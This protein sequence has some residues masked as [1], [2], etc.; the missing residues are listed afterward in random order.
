MYALCSYICAYS[1]PSGHQKRS[2]MAPVLS[3]AN[4][5]QGDGV[6]GD[7]SWHRSLWTQILSLEK[8]SILAD[9]SLYLFV[10]IQAFI[11]HD[12]MHLLQMLVKRQ[13]GPLLEVCLWKT[14]NYFMSNKYLIDIF[15]HLSLD[16]QKSVNCHIPVCFLWFCGLWLWVEFTPKHLWSA[17]F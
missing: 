11:P 9:F 15:L 8:W 17:S 16:K 4:T 12:S 7:M 6:Q 14:Y 13:T 5:F 3:Q 10:F 1:F 2:A